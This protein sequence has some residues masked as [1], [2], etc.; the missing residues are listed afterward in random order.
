VLPPALAVAPPNIDDA[1]QPAT[2][3][4]ARRLADAGRLAEARAACE[5][6][7]VGPGDSPGAYSLLGVILQ[8]QGHT[9][10]AAAAF[11]RALYLDPDHAEALAHLIVLCDARGDTTRAAAL[12]KRLARVTREEPQ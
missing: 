6:L 4:A 3:E 1:A 10:E 7:T 5:R 2:L 12:R 11:R 9:A 8:A